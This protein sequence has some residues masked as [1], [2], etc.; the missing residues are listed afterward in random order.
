MVA[1][2]RHIDPDG[3]FALAAPRGPISLRTSGAR[4]WMLPRRR[5]PEQ[6][7]QSLLLLDAFVAEQCRAFGIGRERVVLGGFSQGASV[8]LGLAALRGRPVPAGVISWCGLVPGGFDV[9]LD[10]S[11]LEGVPVLCLLASDD[12]MISID[13][14]RASAD[15]LRRVGAVVS[16]REYPGRHEITDEMLDDTR[17]WLADIR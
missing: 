5:R 16:S 12:E 8:A 11:R 4:A 9:D 6:F 10:L 7:G 13:R 17:E 15:Q 14:T 2:A 1:A 3:R